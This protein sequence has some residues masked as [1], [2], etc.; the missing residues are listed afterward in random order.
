MTSKPIT[1][2][3]GG[4]TLAGTLVT[5][6]GGDPTRAVL[7]LPGSG[8]LDR[9]GNFKQMTLNVSRDL[10][11]LLTGLGW[12]SLRYDKR[13]VGE[14]E[15]EYLPTGFFDE[16]DDANAA[17]DYLFETAGAKAV[18]VVGHSAG[19]VHG[20]ELASARSD[21]AGVIALALTTKTGAE[22]LKWQ[23]A[24]IEAH[25]VPG[26]A[27]TVMKLLRTSVTKQQAKAIERLKAT[28]EDVERIQGQKINAKWMREFIDYDPHT[29]LR[30]LDAPLL[31]ITGDK[32]I[33]VDPSDLDEVCSIVNGPCTAIR[34]PDV[35]HILRYEAEPHSNPNKYKKKLDQPIDERVTKQI[36]DW[37]SGFAPG[38]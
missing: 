30:S 23:A 34:T 2:D 14:S 29:A 6:N 18:V 36:S 31:A 17:L 7:L 32:D 22:T 8:P 35:D 11:T 16:R 33:Q 4:T 5:P 27:K 12:A 9:N 26:F 25:A 10:A 24:E 13:G 21:V 38:E 1:F 20:V 15:G 28:T 37:L 19:A 3:A